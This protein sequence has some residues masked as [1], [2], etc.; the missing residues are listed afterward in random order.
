[1][2]FKYLSSMQE[3]LTKLGYTTGLLLKLKN[4]KA[5]LAGKTESALPVF[6]PTAPTV[7]RQLPKEATPL[8]GRQQEINA[9]EQLLDEPNCRLVTIIGP[10]GMG[11]T[12]LSLAVAS[13]IEATHFSDG[14]YF[15]PLAVLQ[16]A[17]LILP[18]LAETLGLAA[19]DADNLR[20]QLIYFLQDKRLLLVIDNF[21][22]LLD[23][24]EIV[25]Q[26]LEAA[27]HLK[28]I[29]TSRER[30]N[31][32]G[33]RIFALHGLVFPTDKKASE[34]AICV[35]AAIETTPINP[36]DFYVESWCENLPFQYPESAPK[37]L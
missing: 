26:L 15:L 2:M 6:V 13:Q 16:T 10:G 8:I 22:H 20:K 1:M 11:K 34:L 32:A 29:A 23:G 25:S 24:A 7:V 5:I 14:I 33:E 17:D 37:P 35:D 28:I 3:S 12:R 31:L 18:A 36:F 4:A 27:P 19:A 21:E 9:I 30:L